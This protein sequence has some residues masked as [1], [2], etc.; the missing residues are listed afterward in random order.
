MVASTTITGILLR[1]GGKAASRNARG[2]IAPTASRTVRNGRITREA[3]AS[4]AVAVGE[5]H[6]APR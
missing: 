4:F 2:G 1:S 6:V 3:T 5:H